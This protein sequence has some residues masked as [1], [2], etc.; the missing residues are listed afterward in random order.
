MT[1][2]SGN[3]SEMAWINEAVDKAKHLQKKIVFS[4]QESDLCPS[5]FRFEVLSSNVVT[6]VPSEC[7]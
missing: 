4:Q 6:Y 7:Q 2:I 5:K 3:L 1:R